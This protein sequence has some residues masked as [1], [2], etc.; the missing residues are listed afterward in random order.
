MT[1]SYYPPSM[2]AINAFCFFNV[3]R[4]GEYPFL[5]IQE[6]ISL[7][8]IKAAQY[9]NLKIYLCSPLLDLDFSCI[10]CIS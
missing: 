8:P 6:T 3:L 2:A 9:N 7:F 5:I 4:K 10:N 1:I